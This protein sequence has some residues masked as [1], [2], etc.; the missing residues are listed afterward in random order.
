[1]LLTN[2]YKGILWID[3]DAC[4]HNFDIRL[5]D[6]LIP[7]KHFYKSSDHILRP[8]S[9][10]AGVFLVLNT[11]IGKKLMLDWLNTYDKNNWEKINNKWVSKCKWAGYCYEQGSFIKNISKKYNKYIY[12]L[13][14]YFFQSNYYTI[15]EKKCIFIVH[16]SGNNFKNQI[17][18]YLKFLKDKKQTIKN[19][20]RI[21]KTLKI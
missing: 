2:K 13:N 20:C 17:P 9:F 4:V 19:Y 5:E 3:T 1:L 10:N 21:N 11:E 16:F 15:Y 18:K 12:D 6:I 14:W 8:A 7:N